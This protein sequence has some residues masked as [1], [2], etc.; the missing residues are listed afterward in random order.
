MKTPLHTFLLMLLLLPALIWAE[1]YRE[2]TWEELMPEGWLPPDPMEQIQHDGLPDFTN[3][4]G[5]P[6]VPALNDQ[7]LKIPGYVIP[8]EFKD[9][10]V[11]E[12]LLVPFVGACIHVPPPPENQM[13]YV[14]LKTPLVS[15]SLWEPVWVSGVMKTEASLTKYA[16]VGYRM[17][18]ASTETYVY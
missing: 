18:E 7:K 11:T 14:K 1:D 4:E 5:A 9:D 15:D 6:I 17:V 16:T 10:T 8:L 2:V 12:F 3:R 13:V